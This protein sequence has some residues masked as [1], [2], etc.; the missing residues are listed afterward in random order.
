ME[1][2]GIRGCWLPHLSPPPVPVSR[3]LSGYFWYVG[4]QICYQNYYQCD[5]VVFFLSTDGFSRYNAILDHWFFWTYNSL[6]LGGKSFTG[7]FNGL[8]GVLYLR[9]QKFFALSSSV[10]F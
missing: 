3:F 10:C 1:R 4:L 7:R 9:F 6:S 8:T 5:S 2:S